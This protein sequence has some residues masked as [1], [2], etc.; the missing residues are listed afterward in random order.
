MPY[1][2]S[3]GCLPAQRHI[4]KPLDFKKLLHH[5]NSPE[6]L[7]FGLR[8]ELKYHSINWNSSKIIHHE[9]AK[10]LPAFSLA[11]H[12]TPH[13]QACFLPISRPF[14]GRVSLHLLS[15]ITLSFWKTFLPRLT[16]SPQHL[17]LLLVFVTFRGQSQ[18]VAAG[19]KTAIR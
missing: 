5:Q 14:I 6:L 10:I 11:F 1:T 16:R 8:L 18:Y 9:P 3:A 12:P 2:G 15:L 19:N 13:S 17:W 7:D 4:F